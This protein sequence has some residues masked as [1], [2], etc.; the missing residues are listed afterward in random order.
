MFTNFCECCESGD[1][2]SD[3]AADGLE[4][5]DGLGKVAKRLDGVVDSVESCDERCR[6]VVGRRNVA[7]CPIFPLRRMYLGR[8]RPNVYIFM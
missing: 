6:Q 3:P 2:V 7:M 8:Y 4:V 1:P 5:A